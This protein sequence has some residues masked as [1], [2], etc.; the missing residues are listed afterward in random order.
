MRLRRTL[1]MLALTALASPAFAIYDDAKKAE[2]FHAA[3]ADAQKA[4]EANP[5]N[6]AQARFALLAVSGCSPDDGGWYNFIPEK[7]RAEFTSLV[8]KLWPNE[9]ITKENR[10]EALKAFDAIVM[11][12]AVPT[13]PQEREEAEGPIIV[14]PP[15]MGKEVELTGSVSLKWLAEWL[16]DAEKQYPEAMKRALLFAAEAPSPRWFDYYAAEGAK[17]TQA[18]AIQSTLL[19]LY[20]GPPIV[21]KHSKEE[22]LPWSLKSVKAEL[23]KWGESKD[24]QTLLF[25]AK[26]MRHLLDLAFWADKD[27]EKAK[28]LD[29]KVKALVEKANQIHA[30]EVKSNGVPPERYREKDAAELRKAFGELFAN[31][32][33]QRKVI[34]VSL[35]DDAWV[36]R[37]I[38]TS[39]MNNVQAG[40]YRL[41]DAA[42][43]VKFE[44]RYWVHPVTFAKQWT[45]TGNKFGPPKIHSWSDRYEILAEKAIP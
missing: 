18:R 17:D 39:A 8:A 14:Y 20:L 13:N 42:V 1:F 43:V 35:Y 6:Q 31:D 27:S 12:Y 3:L 29:A 44:K 45:G 22:L 15:V 34:R 38:V 36:E 26:E 9:K 32:N 10:D 7:D 11:K 30:A 2:T 24:P 5:P 19:D 28:E 21:A 33:P 16:T 41:L 4:L 25:R 23:E 40:I 37:A